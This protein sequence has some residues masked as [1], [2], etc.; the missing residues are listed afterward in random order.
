[1]L[2]AGGAGYIGSHTVRL[3]QERG[4]EVAVLDNLSAGHREAVSATLEQAD[5]GDRAALARVFERHRPVAVIHFAAK[6]FVGESVEDP[7]K[8]YR[9]NVTYTW[10]LLEAMRT[11]DCR[12]IVFS[13]T[14][15]TYGEPVQVPMTEDHPQVPINPYGHTKLHMEHM[16]QDYSHAYGMRVA[17]LRYFNAAGA[18]RDGAIGEVHAPETHLIPLVLQVAQGE[19]DEIL[20]FGDDYDTPDGTCIRDYIHVDDL[21]DAHLR[22][23]VKLQAGTTTLACNLGTGSGFSVREVVEAARRVTGHAIPARVVERRPGDPAQ[24]VSGG[25]RAKELL[26]WAPKRPALEDILADAWRFQTAHPKGY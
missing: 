19:R 21:A 3:L 9:E 22:A 23:L 13:S 8:Y 11:A 24:L 14:C 15:A 2:V 1:M 26:G 17:A 12:D 4:V 10:N 16:M 6:C 7:S 25:S 5:L 18:S 20:L